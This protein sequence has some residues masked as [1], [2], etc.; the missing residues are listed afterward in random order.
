MIDARSAVQKVANV[1]VDVRGACRM[2]KCG[3]GEMRQLARFRR[4]IALVR[5]AD[6]VTAGAD[7]EKYLS[8]AR[9]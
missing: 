7:G 6:D 4:K 1:A 2:R 8:R 9:K 5:D 3:R